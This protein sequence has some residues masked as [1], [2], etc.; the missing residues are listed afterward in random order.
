MNVYAPIQHNTVLPHE[1]LYLDHLPSADRYYKSF[2]HRDTINFCVM[3]RL[4]SSFSVACLLLNVNRTDF[5]ITTSV[6]GHL[7]LWKKQEQGIEFVKHY[8][9][10]MSPI[11]GVSAS[12]DG[13]LFASIAEDGTAKVFD[14]VNFGASWPVFTLLILLTLVGPRLRHDQHA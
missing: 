12:A 14:V 6:D 8:R 7:K 9:A 10:H 13:Q 4:E 11:V 5:L 1:K 3:T 2:M